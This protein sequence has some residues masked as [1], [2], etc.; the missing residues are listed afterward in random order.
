[1]TFGIGII[2]R[3]QQSIDENHSQVLYYAASRWILNFLI[4]KQGP[5]GYTF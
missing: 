1:M 2:D 5:S 4:G 3:G